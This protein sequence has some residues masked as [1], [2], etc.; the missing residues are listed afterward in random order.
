MDKV[1]I[2]PGS[3][4]PFTIGHEAIVQQ[5]LNLF[6]RVVIAVGYNPSKSGF[7]PLR[8]RVAL[9][10]D[11][12]AEQ[13]RVEVTSYEGLTVDLSRERGAVAIIRGV[14]S[15]VDFEYER[16]MAAINSRLEGDIATIILFAPTDLADISSS[17][18]RELHSFGRSVDE[19][20]PKGVKIEKYIK[21]I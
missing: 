11:L 18:V 10:E 3:F 5:A 7:M 8:E 19:F 6:D 15:A 9:I 1:V 21:K 4:D 17:V 2:F 20:I 13:S 14:R 12:Y 16:S